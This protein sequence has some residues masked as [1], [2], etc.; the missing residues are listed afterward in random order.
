MWLVLTRCGCPLNTATARFYHTHP[1]WRRIA[2]KTDDQWR[3]MRWPS[4][5]AGSSSACCYSQRSWQI[6]YFFLCWSLD[7][8]GRG[9]RPPRLRWYLLLPGLLARCWSTATWRSGISAGLWTGSEWTLAYLRGYLLSWAS[10]LADLGFSGLV[11]HWFSGGTG[12]S[13]WENS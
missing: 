7:F 6:I 11:F 8:S 13:I 12:W 4:C 5:N 3:V 9:P 10:S 2:C 1:A